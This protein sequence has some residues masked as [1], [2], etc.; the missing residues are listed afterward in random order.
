[1]PK[2]FVNFHHEAKEQLELFCFQAIVFGLR[3]NSSGS[4]FAS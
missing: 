1:M 4:P 3:Q 2:D